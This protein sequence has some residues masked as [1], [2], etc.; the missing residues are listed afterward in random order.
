MAHYEILSI[1]KD[2]TVKYSRI[3]LDYRTQKE[4][5]Y[6]S[7]V[8]VGGNLLFVPGDLSTRTEDLMTTQL[9]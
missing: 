7:R 2:R 9:L 3:L 5:P 4:E 1:S 6:R 8:T